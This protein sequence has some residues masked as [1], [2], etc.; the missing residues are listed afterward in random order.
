MGKDIPTTRSASTAKL[1]ARFLSSLSNID[2]RPIKGEYKAW[3]WIVKHF[4]APSLFFYLAVD[5]FSESALQI[6]QRQSTK[7]LKRW[8]NLP[9]L[10]TL[11]VLFHPP[12][13]NFLT[14]LSSGTKLCSPFWPQFPHLI[15]EASLL[16]S[17]SNY[18]K[19]QSIPQHL[20][21]LLQS[22]KDSVNSL[23]PLPCVVETKALKIIHYEDCYSQ[24]R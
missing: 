3:P 5:K 19:C 18:T 13:L 21:P 15:R 6:L 2:S 10:T 16:L 14:Y 12:V 17:D 8:L 20:C 22:A 4:L 23:Q 1:K 7:I 11:S 24:S 9:R